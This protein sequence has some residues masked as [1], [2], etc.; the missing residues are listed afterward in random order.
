MI[1][2]NMK[3]PL[4]IRLVLGWFA[5]LIVAT[6]GMLGFC[7]LQL[8]GEHKGIG[9]ILT[10][11]AHAVGCL[12]F[13]IGLFYGVIRRKRA[14]V[15]I[16]YL[17]IGA[18]VMIL[19]F[20][21]GHL[22]FS[23]GLFIATLLPVVLMNLPV[24]L[25]WFNE[26]KDQSL[27]IGCG[28]LVLLAAYGVFS[29]CIFPSDGERRRLVASASALSMKGRNL[30]QAINTGDPDLE[31]LL[32]LKTWNVLDAGED[33]DAD[34]FPIMITA[35]FDVNQIPQSWDGVTDQDRV[36]PI[37]GFSQKAL[38]S[39]LCRNVDKQAIIVVRKGG[40]AQVVKAKY[41]TLKNLMGGC[42]YKL[43]KPLRV[44]SKEEVRQMVDR[45]RQDTDLT[46]INT[47]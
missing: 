28:L 31:N 33:T 21:G 39:S 30:Q 46:N 6:L 4:S 15:D 11:A 7:L 18:T 26:E 40:S 22:A 25:R 38:E 12:S 13:P 43:S 19:S 9:P 3:M 14:W 5:I 41:L 47:L 42:S 20:G 8:L 2:S 1:A 34:I 45:L 10:F 35:N 32:D 23:V 37:C 17:I 44:M 16:P 36:L 29:S 24:S 27:G